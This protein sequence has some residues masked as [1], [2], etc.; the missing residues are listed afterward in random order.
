[1][2]EAK[3]GTKVDIEIN[4]IIRRQNELDLVV[5]DVFDLTQQMLKIVI[6]TPI[7]SLKTTKSDSVETN[8]V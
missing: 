8:A 4:F 1:M 3:S 7:P 6:E 2:L 5:R